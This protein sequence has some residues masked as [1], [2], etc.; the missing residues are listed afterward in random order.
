MADIADDERPVP[1]TQE[2][3]VQLEHLNQE[4][5][6]HIWSLQLQMSA[7]RVRSTSAR[8]SAALGLLLV[9]AFVNLGVPW[10]A[11]GDELGSGYA[12]VDDGAPLWWWLHLAAGVFALML[13]VALAAPSRRPSVAGWY[14][15]TIVGVLMTITA[16]GVLGDLPFR[17]DPRAGV[18]VAIALSMAVTVVGAIGGFRLADLQRAEDRRR[19]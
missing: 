5:L 15:L 7:A 9:A 11:V 6:D 1:L 4:H 8:W 17:A 16:V 14:L 19:R 12:L 2:R 18:R 13:V 3:L 10:F